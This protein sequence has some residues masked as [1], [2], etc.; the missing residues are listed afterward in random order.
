VGVVR[1]AV[2]SLP[3]ALSI[4]GQVVS[5]VAW[6]VFTRGVKLLLGAREAA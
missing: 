3:E 4:T 2:T 6:S 1:C 5:T